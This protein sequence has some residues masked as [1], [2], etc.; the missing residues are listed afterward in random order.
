MAAPQGGYPPQEG[1]GQQQPNPYD[2]Q[3]QPNPG[4]PVQ[5]NVPGA[6]PAGGASHGG[7]KKRAYAGQAYDFGSGGNAALGGQQQA[8]G[9]YGGYP[10]PTQQQGYPQPAYGMDQTQAAAPGYSQPDAAA[11]GGYQ[12]P[13]AGY[14]VP[15]TAGVQQM[16]QQFGQMGVSDPS[17]MQ[18]QAPVSRTQLNQL[19][20]TDLLTQPFN[21]A[22]LDFPPPPIVLPSNVSR[23]FDYLR[24][25]YT[26]FLRLALHLLHMRTALRNTSAQP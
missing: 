7:R 10:A 11:V 9:A 4:S 5:A 1:Y 23:V 17:Q 13:T 20:P 16:T 2:Q 22:E 26:N 15:P 6:D 3:A 21:V 24:V 18:P 12:A 25:A 14:P 8:G 19:Y